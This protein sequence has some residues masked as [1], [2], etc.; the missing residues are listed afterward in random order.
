MTATACRTIA[1]ATLTLAITA[2]R[3][4][5]WAGEFKQRL[6][7]FCQELAH[8][9]PSQG[10]PS[11]DQFVQVK[12]QSCDEDLQRHEH[13]VFDQGGWQALVTVNERKKVPES[14]VDLVKDVLNVAGARSKREVFA[15]LVRQQGADVSDCP[16]WES[17]FARVTAGPGAKQSPG[18]PGRDL[19]TEGFRLYKQKKYVEAAKRFEQALA[20]EPG[21]AL[22]HY[23][24]ACT[25]ALL[26][27]RG[28]DCARGVYREAILDHLAKAV[29]L[30]EK[31][32]ARMAVDADLADVRG[33]F[34][35][36]V[37]KGLSPAKTEDVKAILQH[38]AWEG[39]TVEVYGPASTL[40]FQANG[41]CVLK[42][43]DA[44]EDK[45]NWEVYR[46]TYRVQGNQ[47]V[48]SL[49]K[50]FAS[51]K[52]HQGKLQ[53]DGRLTF[54]SLPEHA[55]FTDGPPECAGEKPKR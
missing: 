26:Y 25:L 16:G 41:S 33:T 22:A 54:A 37:L 51:R 27:K 3:H 52:S 17:F 36:Q 23:N 9:S 18:S 34:R 6:R 32:R 31:R 49:A 35:Y 40:R 20:A 1:F 53:A 5:A 2:N 29:D 48:L 24:L 11:P 7:Q 45:V 19:N 28:P 12:C 38:V 46:G 15:Q 30:D 44:F 4:P 55:P 39:P 50:P 43:L 42:I 21:F 8:P 47:V 13:T 14:L 10:G